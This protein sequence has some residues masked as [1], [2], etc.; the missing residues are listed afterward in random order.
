ML[1]PTVSIEQW[2]IDRATQITGHSVVHRLHRM[3]P[4]LAR[5]GAVTGGVVV[6]W[7][8]GVI[9][10]IW[11]ES[12]G[13]M[14]IGI[15]SMIDDGAPQPDFTGTCVLSIDPGIMAII[16]ALYDDGMTPLPGFQTR[17]FQNGYWHG[18]IMYRMTQA[19]DPFVDLDA[20]IW[21]SDGTAGGATNTCRWYP[22]AAP[23]PTPTP[24]PTPV[25]TPPGP[26][27][28]QQH[29]AT[30]IIDGKTYVGTLIG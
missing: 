12:D 3:R 30:V 23:V 10:F 29:Q 22:P 13:P 18:H 16:L 5:V 27:P 21:S 19:A 9:P 4:R 17:P 11:H 20:N 2:V 7:F 14:P 1:M 26:T 6:G 28:G 8:K 25:P 24:V 15:A